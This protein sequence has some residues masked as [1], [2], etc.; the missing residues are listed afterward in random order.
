MSGRVCRWLS[1]AA[2]VGV[3]IP[4]ARAQEDTGTKVYQQ[5]LRSTVWILAA[6]EGNKLATGTGSIIDTSRR[7]ILT[8]Y[9]VVGDQAEAFV[10]FPVFRDGRPVAER[11]EYLQMFRNGQAKRARVRARDTRHDLAL[12]ELDEPNRGSTALRLARHSPNPGQRVHSIGNPG[13]TD[14]L[15]EY[16]SGTVRAVYHKQWEVREGSR[17]LSFNAEVVETQS[18][19][20][21]GDSGGPLVNDRGELVAVTQGYNAS[22]QLLS[23]FVDVKEVKNFLAA[24]HLMARLPTGSSEPP[25]PTKVK[26]ETET[27]AVPVDP[28]QKASEKLKFARTLVE[29]GRLEKAKDRCQEIIDNFPMT[30]AAGDAKLLLDK[31]NK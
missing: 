27:A 17:T 23:L 5:T 29:A 21:R 11:R 18:P 15:W 1:L 9:H 30:K 13:D 7:L 31:L 19:T 28:E 6:H 24:Q 12:V 20:N 22:G 25:T 26:S 14:A 2:I 16:T 8:N 3:T 4:S 10:L